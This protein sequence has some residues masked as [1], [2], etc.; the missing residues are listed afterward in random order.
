MGCIYDASLNCT[1]CNIICALCAIYWCCYATDSS[2]TL[3][4]YYM[5][6]DLRGLGI[7]ATKQTIVCQGGD[8]EDR[9]RLSLRRAEPGHLATN[10]RIDE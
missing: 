1:M 4:L 8:G 7:Y 2:G 9:L 3:C 5:H 10:K 6:T